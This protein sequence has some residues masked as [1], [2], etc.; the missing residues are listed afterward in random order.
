MADAGYGSEENY[1]MMEKKFS[2]FSDE[3]IA[4]IVEMMKDRKQKKKLK[5]LDFS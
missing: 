4:E 2:I 5:F 1:E 3:K